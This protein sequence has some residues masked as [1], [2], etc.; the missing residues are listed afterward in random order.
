MC[1]MMMSVSEVVQNFSIASYKID[2]LVT[3]DS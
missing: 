1:I 2:S 3:F